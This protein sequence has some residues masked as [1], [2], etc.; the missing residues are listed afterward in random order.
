MGEH[1]TNPG[2]IIDRALVREIADLPAN[3][4]N[5]VSWKISLGLLGFVLLSALGAVTLFGPDGWLPT[6]KSNLASLSRMLVN[7]LAQQKYLPALQPF[8]PDNPD[9]QK[10]FQED[11][12]S[13]GIT[14]TADARE[15]EAN[16]ATLFPGRFNQARKELEKAGLQWSH[17]VPV[18]CAFGCANVNTDKTT[19]PVRMAFGQVYIADG[20]GLYFIEIA[21]RKI[22]HHYYLTEIWNW[23]PLPVKP[24]ALETYAREHLHQFQQERR[25]GKISLSRRKT[26]F[27]ML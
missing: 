8:L 25:G 3:E 1:S 23:G 18:A 19:S 22:G 12:H 6:E 7:S 17:A 5:S 16:L 27:V 13:I 14:D 11:N 15:E 9:V 21:A 10:K 24:D 2:E 26:F 4:K 20:Y